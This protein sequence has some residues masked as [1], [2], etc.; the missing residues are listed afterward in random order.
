MRV[1]AWSV[2][3]LF[4]AAAATGEEVSAPDQP[5]PASAEAEAPVVYLTF[6]DGPSENTVKILDTLKEHQVPATFFVCGNVTEFGRTVYNRII[7]EG[8]AIGNH[9]FSHS[10]AKVYASV[11]AFKA[12]VKKLDD[13]IFTFTG[14]RTRLLRYPGGSNNRV[15]TNGTGRS[16]MHEIVPAMLKE[17]YAHFDWDIDSFDSGKNVKDKDAIVA[18]VVDGCGS[19]PRA[20][21]LLHDSYPRVA[22]TEA[23]PEIIETLKARGFRF[24]AL[25]ETSYTRRFQK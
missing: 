20:I 24:E 13:L 22:T 6:D 4:A 17:G 12:D 9:T 21:V 10:Y 7:D 18:A 1:T 15:N 8:H 25:S 2:L 16:V 14:K 11:E 23:L 5:P 3:L 19:R